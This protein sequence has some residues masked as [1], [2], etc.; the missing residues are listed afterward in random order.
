MS[1]SLIGIYSFIYFIVMVTYSTVGSVQLSPQVS[2]CLSLDHY[3]FFFIRL[4]LHSHRRGDFG[5]VYG[6]ELECC[7]SSYLSGG[8]YHSVFEF[9]LSISQLYG[10]QL[11]IVSPRGSSSIMVSFVGELF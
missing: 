11:L 9:E 3:L 2:E 10:Q 6:T 1:I 8:R 4:S 7:R 5:Q